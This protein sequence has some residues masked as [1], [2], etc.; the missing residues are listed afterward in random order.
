[1]NECYL[2]FAVQILSRG[3]IEFNYTEESDGSST[4]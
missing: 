2:I 3:G 1:M 4:L